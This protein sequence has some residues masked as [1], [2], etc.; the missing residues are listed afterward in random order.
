M[1]GQVYLQCGKSITPAIVTTVACS[2]SSEQSKTPPEE[3]STDNALPDKKN[4]K[5]TSSKAKLCNV[6]STM[7]KKRNTVC[8]QSSTV[9]LVNVSKPSAITVG[10]SI[11]VTTDSSV[12][13]TTHTRSTGNN[14]PISKNS[15]HLSNHNKQTTSLSSTLISDTKISISLCKGE[16]TSSKIQIPKE[17]VKSIQEA[18]VSSHKHRLKSEHL[19]VSHAS[20]TPSPTRNNQDTFSTPLSCSF[21]IGSSINQHWEA[22]LT[23]TESKVHNDDMSIDTGL[24][25]PSYTSA[26]TSNTTVTSANT[27][28]F[29]VEGLCDLPT[30]TTFPVTNDLVVLA[31]KSSVASECTVV[32]ALPK[33]VSSSCASESMSNQASK[34]SKQIWT[35]ETDMEI[36]LYIQ[37]SGPTVEAFQHLAEKL[38][39]RTIE[40]VSNILICNYNYTL[41]VAVPTKYVTRI[42]I[43]DTSAEFCTFIFFI[44]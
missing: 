1:D 21:D 3:R 43:R 35:K 8:K 23:S 32:S 36:L 11:V 39:G 2:S 9:S 16:A 27:F 38:Q 29:V 22:V 15:L 5:N 34:H 18:G 28:D 10:K 26:A 14:P 42:L 30:S 44:F 13:T 19:P 4:K 17:S 25:D 37:E 6:E 24:R 31:N 41:R 33:A 40:Q 12:P 7:S 20:D